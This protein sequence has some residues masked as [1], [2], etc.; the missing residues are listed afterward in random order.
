MLL[1]LVQLGKEVDKGVV[2]RDGW[3]WGWGGSG[4]VVLLGERIVLL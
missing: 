1:G 3:G 2:G 4:V